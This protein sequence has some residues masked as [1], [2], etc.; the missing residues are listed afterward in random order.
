MHDGCSETLGVLRNSHALCQKALKHN[1][2]T[3]TVKNGVTEKTNDVERNFVAT[4]SKKNDTKLR[5]MSAMSFLLSHVWTFAK[6]FSTNY[7]CIRIAIN[8]R[9]S[10]HCIRSIPFLWSRNPNFLFLE[11][12]GHVLRPSGPF[13]KVR[14]PLCHESAWVMVTPQNVIFGQ[15]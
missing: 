2:N 5:F 4:K 8:H 11:D 10:C 15:K 6:S 7:C 3:I 12:L 1:K 14:G 9:R 13:L